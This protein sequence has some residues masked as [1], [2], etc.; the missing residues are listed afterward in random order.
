M[1]DCLFA[2]SPTN[3]S[4]DFVFKATTEGVVLFPSLFS[5]TEGS[6]ESITAIAELVVPKSIPITLAICISFSFV[7]LYFLFIAISTKIGRSK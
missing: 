2:V 4:L 6:P 5:I 3:L 1:I 7:F